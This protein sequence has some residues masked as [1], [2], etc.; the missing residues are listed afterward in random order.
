MT[1]ESKKD[2]AGKNSVSD[3]LKIKYLVV[4]HFCVPTHH[5]NCYFHDYI[6]FQLL[7]SVFFTVRIEHGMLHK[8]LKIKDFYVSRRCSNSIVSTVVSFS[9]G[10]SFTSLPFTGTGKANTIFFI[11]LPSFC[12]SG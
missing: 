1:L 5:I 6:F 8:V 4:T 10:N 2:T 9:K 11:Q 3:D 12:F 7:I